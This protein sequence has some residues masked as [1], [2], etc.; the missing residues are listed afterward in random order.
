M[1]ISSKSPPFSCHC[2][3]TKGVF[4]TFLNGPLPPIQETSPTMVDILVVL[5]KV[6][7]EVYLQNK[8]FKLR[9]GLHLRVPALQSFFSP[10]DYF[11]L[12]PEWCKGTNVKLEKR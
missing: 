4:E 3:P 12:A 7:Q 8:F 2:P 6:V 11:E 1:I 10:E 5:I 9:I